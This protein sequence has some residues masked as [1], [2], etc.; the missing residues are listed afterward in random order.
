MPRRR[1]EAPEEFDQLILE[2]IETH[3]IQVVDELNVAFRGEAGFGSTGIQ[4]V[5]AIDFEGE[6]N[7]STR[8]QSTNEQSTQFKHQDPIRVNSLKRL[9]GSRK[10][11]F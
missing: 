4:P 8:N 7:G 2:R 6:G 1:L 5:P 9:K 10:P 3:A 11:T